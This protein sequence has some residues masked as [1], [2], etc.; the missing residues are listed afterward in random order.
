MCGSN[1]NIFLISICICILGLLSGSN[2]VSLIASFDHDSS[3][4]VSTSKTQPY[5]DQIE[6]FIKKHKRV[7]SYLE[8]HEFWEQAGLEV[9]FSSEVDIPNYKKTGADT[10]TISVQGPSVGDSLIYSSSSD[11]W[12][13]HH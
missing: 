10:Y 7:P 3:I 13:V 1:I 5:V 2:L 9:N 6:A 11:S 4:A 8:I 12:S